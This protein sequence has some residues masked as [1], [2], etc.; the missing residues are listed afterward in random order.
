MRKITLCL[1]CLFLAFSGCAER[2]KY[3]AEYEEALTPDYCFEN[4]MEADPNLTY[5]HAA[6]N[7]IGRYVNSGQYIDY[8]GIEGISHESYL[9]TRISYVILS[10][11]YEVSVVKSKTLEEEPI[12]DLTAVSAKIYEFKNVNTKY[13]NKS[14]DDNVAN[15]GSLLLNEEIC[16]LDAEYIASYIREKLSSGE[17]IENNSIHPRLT[18]YKNAEDSYLALRI[19][20]DE[21]ENLVWDSTIFTDNDNYYFLCYIFKSGLLDEFY[22]PVYVIVPE[23]IGSALSADG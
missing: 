15:Y 6:Y 3:V 9:G 17:Y 18:D 1:L 4:Y 19:C 12:Y 5:L 14:T 13:S 16:A 10:L 22:S 8:Y 2:Y 21:Y 7:S 20:F 23:E 11:S